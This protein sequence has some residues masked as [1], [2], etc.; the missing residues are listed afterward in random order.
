MFKLVKTSFPLL[1]LLLRFFF[2]YYW[3]LAVRLL[4][5]LVWFL[6]ACFLFSEFLEYIGFVFLKFGNSSAFISSDIFSDS[7]SFWDYSYTTFRLPLIFLQVLDALFFIS[8]FAFYFHIFN[9]RIFFP[10]TVES[11]ARYIQF[12]FFFYLNTVFFIFRDS[13]DSFQSNYLFSIFH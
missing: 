10:C 5:A 13:F 9:L 7:L 2:L 4:R 12:F 1:S 6:C 3:I 8:F 11:V